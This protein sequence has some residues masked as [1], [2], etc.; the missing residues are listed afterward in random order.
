MPGQAIS[1]NEHRRALRRAGVRRSTRSSAVR[2][3]N[4]VIG[5]L[6]FVGAEAMFFAGLISAFLVLR[7]ASEVWPPADQPRLPLLVTTINTLVLLASAYTMQRAVRAN[8][9]AHGLS[10]SEWLGA[11]LLLG[12]VFL[13]VQGSEWVRL[14]SYG[15]H[16]TSSL[17]SAT[18]YVLIGAHGLHVL[19]AVIALTLVRRGALT[20]R[21][22]SRF[23]AA[24]EACRI[25]WFFVV[26][27]WPIL[28]VL[29]Y[30]L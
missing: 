30:L 3:P 24:V 2:L 4:A 10:T 8:R 7:A 26:G 22:A 28:Y 18:F 12:V 5:T 1:L 17:Y 20:G 15:F 29:V 6:V 13:A 16:A 25:Y 21:D 19:G 23:V 14:L 27:V 11:T 9:A